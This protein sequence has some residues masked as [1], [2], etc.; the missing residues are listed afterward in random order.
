MACPRERATPLGGVFF[1]Q[2]ASSKRLPISPDNARL[3]AF[4]LE[5]LIGR[6]SNCQNLPEAVDKYYGVR[7]D[8]CAPARST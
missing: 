3:S 2:A 4:Q 5:W 7:R 1:K 8:L 6:Y